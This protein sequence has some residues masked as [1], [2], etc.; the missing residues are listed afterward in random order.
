[1]TPMDVALDHLPSLRLGVVPHT[2]AYSQI[3]PAFETLGGIAGRAG[4]FNEASTVMLGVYHDDPNVTAPADLRSDAAVTL[5]DGAT[6]PDGLVERHV[7][8]GRYA[9]YTH[10]GPYEMLVDAWTRFM[11]DGLPASGC[12]LRDGPAL[13]IYR[14]DPGTTPPAQLHTDLMLPVR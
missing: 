7:A 13:E 9:R 1:M 2:G 4:L 11:S 8:G 6:L 5:T 3:G 10:I 14:N 12:E